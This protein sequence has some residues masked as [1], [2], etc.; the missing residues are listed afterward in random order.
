MSEFYKVH[1]A[2][3]QCWPI[4]IAFLLRIPILHDVIKYGTWLKLICDNSTPL[5]L[6]DYD[7]DYHQMILLNFV[8]KV[9]N[10]LSWVIH[11]ILFIFDG[12]WICICLHNTHYSSFQMHKMNLD[13]LCPH[14]FL[15]VLVSL[16]LNLAGFNLALWLVWL[17]PSYY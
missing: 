7:F 12:Y 16:Q 14:L 2:A 3:I 4:S 11:S 15:W 1:L 6:H 8:K 9:L 10:T 5:H 13:N 17:L